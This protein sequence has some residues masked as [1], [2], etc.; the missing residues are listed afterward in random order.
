VARCKANNSATKKSFQKTSKDNHSDRLYSLALLDADVVQTSG[1]R[2]WEPSGAL[3]I[4][5][6]IDPAAVAP[7]DG[8]IGLRS[9]FLG[10]RGSGSRLM[11]PAGSHRRKDRGAKSGIE[12][13]R[14]SRRDHTTPQPQTFRIGAGPPQKGDRI[15]QIVDLLGLP[16]LLPSGVAS[17]RLILGPRPFVRI[18]GECRSR[19]KASPRQVAAVRKR[20]LSD[21]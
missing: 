19:Q 12:T 1:G 2:R 3:S 8:T 14:Q 16:S 18:L 7:R 5:I 9:Y 20:V 11:W 15:R 6:R 13:S 17:L 10:E 4:G 21:A